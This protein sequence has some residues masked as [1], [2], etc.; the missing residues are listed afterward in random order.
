MNILIISEF[1]LINACVKT[2]SQKVFRINDINIITQ[3]SNTLS[4]LSRL[5]KIKPN[6]IFFDLD[7]T[8][9]SALCKYELKMKLLEYVNTTEMEVCFFLLSTQGQI[10]NLPVLKNPILV[11]PF[12]PKCLP[13]FIK[14]QFKRHSEAL[15]PK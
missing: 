13:E 15:F 9:T 8:S 2:I 12:S 3:G 6:I 1:P 11:K 7:S 5:P 4:I 14:A 10:E